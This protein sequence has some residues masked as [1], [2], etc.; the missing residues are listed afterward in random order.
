MF[1]DLRD[2]LGQSGAALAVA[3]LIIGRLFAQ[4]VNKHF[5]AP[6]LKLKAQEIEERKQ[7]RAALLSASRGLHRVGG[8]LEHG[9]IT[10]KPRVV[11]D[12]AKH[13]TGESETDRVYRKEVL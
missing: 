6:Y 12:T 8:A 1:E 7:S 13:G 10:Y 4:Y 3:L 2:L 5:F 11:R 9:S